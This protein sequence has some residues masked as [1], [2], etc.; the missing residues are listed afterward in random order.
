MGDHRPAVALP[1]PTWPEALLPPPEGGPCVDCKDNGGLSAQLKEEMWGRGLSVRLPAGSLDLG[2]TPQARLRLRLQA[3][4]HTSGRT[5]TAHTH[6]GS[7]AR[8][9]RSCASVGPTTEW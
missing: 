5:I 6:G 4:R 3:G 9:S 7:L 1:L 8:R 2:A